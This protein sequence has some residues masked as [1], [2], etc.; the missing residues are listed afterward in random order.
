[1]TRSLTRGLR[2]IRREIRAVL[3]SAQGG[4]IHCELRDPEAQIEAGMRGIPRHVKGSG[5]TAAGND[6]IVPQ[7]RQR[8][9]P[10]HEHDELGLRRADIE[11]KPHQGRWKRARGGRRGLPRHTAAEKL[12]RG[13]RAY[14]QRR[15]GACSAVY[16]TS[17]SSFIAACTAGR[18]ATRS[19]KARRLGNGARSNFTFGAHVGHREEIGVGHREFVTQQEGTA[20]KLLFDDG[21]ALGEIGLPLR[22]KSP[23]ECRVG[24]AA[25]RSCAAPS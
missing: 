20:R 11:R 16:L 5:E 12:R 9:G 2:N 22:A 17:P 1:M 15:L 21:V 19:W 24:R 3:G 7:R 14:R 8:A 6:V 4:V 18:A 13:R 23:P 25:N 10:V